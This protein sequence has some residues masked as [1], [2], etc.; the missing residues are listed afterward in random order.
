M[1]VKDKSYIRM[2]GKSALLAYS[3]NVLATTNLSIQVKYIFN[4]LRY[5]L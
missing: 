4:R 1:K 2:L 5:F 3:F